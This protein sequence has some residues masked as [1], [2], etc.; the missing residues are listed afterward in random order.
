MYTAGGGLL[1]MKGKA[2]C[3]GPVACKAPEVEVESNVPRARNLSSD[4]M[5]MAFMSRTQTG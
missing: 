4:K 2:S 5:A 1:R 3:L